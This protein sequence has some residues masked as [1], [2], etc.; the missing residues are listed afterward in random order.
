MSWEFM[1]GR[2]GCEQTGSPGHSVLRRLTLRGFKKLNKSPV[3]LLG[4]PHCL[5]PLLA[6]LAQL[7]PTHG[8]TI[9]VSF[10]EP[11][12]AGCARIMAA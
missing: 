3:T 7:R 9:G 6:N 5:M 2:A 4:Q 12:I 10:L 1:N 8:I 11:V